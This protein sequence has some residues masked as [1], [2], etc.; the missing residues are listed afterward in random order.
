MKVAVVH[1]NDG[2]DVRVSKLCRSLGRLGHETHFVGWDRRPA[3][4]K[5][6]DLAATRKHI[7]V[8]ATRYGKGSALG[9][10]RFAVFLFRTLRTIRP[11]VV[12]VVNEEIAF[13][14][15]PFRGL[16]YR[17]MICD[18]FD[19]LPDRHSHRRRSL[20]RLLQGIA[21]AVQARAD[22]VVATDETRAGFLTADRR[23]IAVIENFPE[24]PGETFARQTPTGEIAVWVGGTLT[25]NRGLEQ[26]LEAVAD[27]PDVRIFSAGWAYDSYAA[28]VFLKDPKV[29][30]LGILTPQEALAAAAR[31]D[32][33]LAYYLPL[34][35][36]NVF[37]SPNKIYDALS[38]GR[39][40]IINREVTV[41]RFVAENDLGFTCAYDDIASLR[42]IL[43][44]LRAN[45]R[46]LD[47]FATRSRQLFLSR[48]NWGR[49]EQRMAQILADL[50]P[51]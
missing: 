45:R 30:Y 35:K 24:D 48:F 29:S 32:A 3:E 46:V 4:T 42:T 34:S 28:D 11:D 7:R 2:T 15:L 14:A 9:L 26:I 33:I 51:R 6:L 17:R 44:S 20:V 18:I 39:P 27:L 1:V 13:L 10:G 50:S 19:S 16:L 21:N 36:N 25:R 49:M 22:K 41:A 40:V 31:C 8:E 43:M 47:D 12:W 37:A 5:T 38:I 23:R